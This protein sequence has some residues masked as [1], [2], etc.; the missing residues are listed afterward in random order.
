MM[1]KCFMIFLIGLVVCMLSMEAFADPSSGPGDEP[2]NVI[3][4]SKY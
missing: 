4:N 2:G 1:K 3:I